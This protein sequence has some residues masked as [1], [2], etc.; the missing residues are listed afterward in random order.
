MD[1]VELTPDLHMLRFPVG[2]A[3]LLRDEDSLTLI[4][5]GLPGAGTDI[6]RTIRGIGMDPAALRH[7]VL[8]HFHG[9]HVGSAAE[10]TTLGEVTVAAHRLDAPVIRG[11][12]PGPPP[13]LLDWERP[14]YESITPNMPAVP[15]ARVDR[16][17][18]GG[19]VLDVAGGAHILSIPGHTDGS[20][21]V[22]LP[23][24][25]FLF[26]GDAVANVGGHTMLGVFNTDHARAVDSFHRLAELDVELACFGH[27]ATE[28]LQVDLAQVAEILLRLVRGAGLAPLCCGDHDKRRR[29]I[30]RTAGKLEVGRTCHRRPPRRRRNLVPRPR[31]ATRPTGSAARPSAGGRPSPRSAG[32]SSSSY[33][34]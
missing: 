6:A 1:I 30:R 8:T 34:R 29:R 13:V 27:G 18:D 2:Q 26:T 19:E 15:P 12:R 10:I 20:I 11:E 25:R 23:R 4:D 28:A 31:C 14:L 32:P 24:R 22:Y 17:L 5:T 3:Y 16:E 9:D 7:V 33:R 21:A